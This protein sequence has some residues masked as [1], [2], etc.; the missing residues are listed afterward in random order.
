MRGFTWNND[1]KDNEPESIIQ[2][3]THLFKFLLSGAIGQETVTFNLEYDTKKYFFQIEYTQA[4]QIRSD[5]DGIRENH[6][7][8]GTPEVF[9][10]IYFKLTQA[11][12]TSDSRKKPQQTESLD[13]Q[14]STGTD[15]LMIKISNALQSC[16]Y[17]VVDN[18]LPQQK[19]LN[20]NNITQII[21]R[22]TIADLYPLEL[23]DV[24]TVI[25]SRIQ[26]N[27]ELIPLAVLDAWTSLFSEFEDS[28]CNSEIY[29]QEQF[30][31]STLQ[32]F[33]MFTLYLMN[34]NT[35]LEQLLSKVLKEVQRYIDNKNPFLFSEFD[36]HSLDTLYTKMH[37]AYR[38]KTMMPNITL[39]YPSESPE[40]SPVTDTVSV[41]SMNETLQLQAPKAR[42]KSGFN[43]SDVLD[44]MIDAI[45]CALKER[46]SEL[47][48]NGT[49]KNIA[50]QL[51]LIYNSTQQHNKQEQ[52]QDSKI[53][54]AIDSEEKNTQLLP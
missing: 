31:M 33:S 37:E 27:Q 32:R 38:Y 52:G 23:I 28:Y 8:I 44:Q 12:N 35:P 3:N 5:I 21:R 18:D 48:N 49:V 7:T 17:T 2:I 34:P 22:Q 41:I 10:D 47:K 45:N 9:K 25:S 42:S 54:A 13:C 40:T 43:N 4:E 16:R 30:S 51:S 14:T 11:T 46:Q 36:S 39:F 26:G 1:A 29:F 53:S 6:F 19:E 50:H 24:F 15:E 20:E